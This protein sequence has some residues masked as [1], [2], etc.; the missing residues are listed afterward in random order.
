[1]NEKN[2]GWKNSEFESE[3]LV[4]FFLI[5]FGWTW[6]YWSVFIFQL[7]TMPEGM[8]TPNVNLREALV[9]IPLVVFSP[10]GPTFAAFILTYLNEGRKAAARAR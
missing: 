4:K 7:V 5:A 8:G 1:M 3:N 6:L 9:F 10:Y 2:L